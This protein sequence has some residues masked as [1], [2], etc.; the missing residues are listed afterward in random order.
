MRRL[1]GLIIGD[2][3]SAVAFPFGPRRDVRIRAADK[4]A[5]DRDRDILVDRA[6]MGLLLL[7]AKLGQ[8]L[9]DTIRLDL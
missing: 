3:D 4:L 5:L 8:Q 7:D 9:E 6:G 2:R 1:L